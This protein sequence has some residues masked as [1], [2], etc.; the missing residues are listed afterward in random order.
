MIELITPR[1]TIRDPNMADLQGWHNLMSDPKT[2][3]YLDSMRTNNEEESRANL[4]LAVEESVNPNR[5][6]YFFAM[7]TRGDGVFIGSIGY[8]IAEDDLQGKIANAGYFILPRYWGKGF[9]TE[10][11]SRVIQFAF[12]ENGMHCLK[13]SCFAQNRASER[14]MQ[15]CGMVK[16]NE[17]AERVEYRLNA[18]EW[19]QQKKRMF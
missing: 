7:E 6:K 9:T 10:A 16:Q 3:F 1:L 2:M 17:T 11:F 5:T 13:A 19:R 4:L 15:K 8:T 14:V 12:E 18:G